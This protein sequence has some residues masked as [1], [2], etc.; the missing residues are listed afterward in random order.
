VWLSLDDYP[1]RSFFKGESAIV[2]Y[3]LNVDEN[4]NPT[5]C[6][7][8]RRT[9]PPEFAEITCSRLMQRARFIPAINSS[10]KPVAAYFLGTVRWLMP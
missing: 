7:V 6:E 4:G 9:N 10:G 2:R 5:S 8:Q 3:R 1:D